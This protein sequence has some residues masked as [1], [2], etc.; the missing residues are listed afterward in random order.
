MEELVKYIVGQLAQNKEQVEVTSKEDEKG[1]VITVKVDSDDMGR[2][3]GKGGKVAQAIR[4][5]VKTA[6]SKTN[7]KYVVKFEERA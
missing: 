2:V 6:S 7:K 5:I 3:I 1:I 4:S